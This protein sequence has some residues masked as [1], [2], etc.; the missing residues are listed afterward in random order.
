MRRVAATIGLLVL[1]ACGEPKQ[2]NAAPIPKADAPAPAATATAIQAAEAWVGR[3][4]GVEGLF[5]EV[6][7]R[8]AE[9]LYPITLKDNLDAQAD[10]LATPEE[11]GLAFHRGD[12]AI[13]IRPGTG[14]ETGFKYLSGKRDCLILVTGQEG[15]CRD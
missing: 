6:Q 9:G 5:L 13:V 4:L 3:W 14:T 2:E 10:Y 15:Y 1:A 8:N 11:K 7:P 12:D